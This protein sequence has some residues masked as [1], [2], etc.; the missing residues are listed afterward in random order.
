ML[1]YTYTSTYTCRMNHN[2]TIIKTFTCERELETEQSLQYIDLTSPSGHSRESFSFSWWSTGGPGANSA[3]FFYCILSPTGLVPKLH[4]GSQGSLLLGGGFP[5]HILSP[6]RLFS[7]SS[8][9]QLSDFLFSPIN[10]I[11]QSP[12]QSPTQSLEWNV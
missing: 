6:T 2:D 9:L 11:V 8:D 5:K 1:I 12:T 4:R 7:N 3:V 10:I